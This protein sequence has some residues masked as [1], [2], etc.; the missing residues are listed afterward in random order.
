MI[1]CDSLLLNSLETYLDLDFYS[2][3]KFFNII[4]VYSKYIKFNP[5]ISYY[6]FLLVSSDK[7]IGNTSIN[8]T[9][10]RL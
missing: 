8:V 9:D 2:R 1:L 6:F 5:R 3:N 10:K 4:P 7:L